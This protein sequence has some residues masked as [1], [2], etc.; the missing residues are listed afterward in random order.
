VNETI[1]GVTLALIF[2]LL[3]PAMLT[4]R[5]RPPSDIES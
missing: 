5:S 2:G 1:L 3:I 4:H